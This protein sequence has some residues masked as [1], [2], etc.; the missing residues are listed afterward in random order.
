[1]DGFELRDVH[2]IISTNEFIVGAALAAI[3]EFIAIIAAKTAPTAMYN[4]TK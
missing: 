3:I 2:K 1:M 4:L